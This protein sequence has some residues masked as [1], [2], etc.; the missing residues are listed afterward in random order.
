VS[1]RGLFRGV[2]CSLFDDPEYQALHAEARLVL[3]TARQCREAAAGAIF[4][5][6]PGVLA[7]QTGLTRRRLETRLNDLERA[8]WT[9]GAGALDRQRSPVGPDNPPAGP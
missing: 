6:Y 1:S 4:R 3:L 2:Y 8:G 5:Y 7:Q 9:R